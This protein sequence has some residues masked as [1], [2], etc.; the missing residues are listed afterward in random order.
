MGELDIAAKAL[1]REDPEALVRLALPGRTINA[2]EPDETEFQALERRMDKLMRVEIAGEVEPVWV[3]VEV[4][5]VWG[6]DVPR[7]I[8][9]YWSLAHHTRP[10]ARSLVLV[11]QPGEK[12]GAPSDEYAVSVLGRPV[13]SFR[14][15]VVCAWK[16]KAS[17]LLANPDPGLLPL[18]PFTDGAS[19]ERV[20]EALRVLAS[21]PKAGNLQVVLAAFSTQ[22]FPA[23]AWFAKIPKEILMESTVFKEIMAQ[24]EVAG[25]RRI[26]A[27]QLRLRLGKNKRT[28]GLVARLPLC[29]DAALEKVGDLLVGSK[30]KTDLLLAVEKLIPK[31]PAAE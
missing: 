1:L 9:G 30:K 11:L 31:A 17:E 7:R 15:D 24:G 22:V 12:Q 29:T 16:L 28:E 10:V 26:V 21:D 23:E 25:L 5:A 4:E 20:E 2:I 13:L 3:H 27:R 14:Y 8:F 6:A 18:L 19:P